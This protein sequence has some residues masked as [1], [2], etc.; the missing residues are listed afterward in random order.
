MLPKL[1]IFILCLN[2]I[3]SLTA[4]SRGETEESIPPYD[5]GIEGWQAL[6]IREVSEPIKPVNKKF[7][8]LLY[9]NAAKADPNAL[10]LYL[11]DFFGQALAT[12][13]LG[14]AEFF[15]QKNH[16][17]D[18]R[19]TVLKQPT[20]FV[21][22]TLGKEERYKSDLIVGFNLSAEERLFPQLKPTVFKRYLLSGYITLP[23]NSLLL[24]PSQP[25]SG[26]RYALARLSAE[27]LAD[28]ESLRGRV[29]LLEHRL[30]PSKEGQIG[31]Y[32]KILAELY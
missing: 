3:P 22:T 20:S 8:Q 17:K 19:F 27:I 4:F 7:F 15:L 6:K 29:W 5:P 25:E 16:L 10:N 9:R 32:I 31:L 14:G 24:N 26:I 21:R 12:Y 2:L 28:R 13:A 18:I 11:R 1:F 23:L 30:F